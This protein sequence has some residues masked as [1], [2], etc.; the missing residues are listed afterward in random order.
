MEIDIILLEILFIIKMENFTT[1]EEKDNQIQKN[2]IRI[3]L[4]EIEKGI[5]SN[6]KV[7]Q[8][9]VLQIE[10]QIVAFYTGLISPKRLKKFCLEKLPKHMIPNSFIKLEEFPYDS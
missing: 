4:G 3:E 1:L 2:G 7:I 8:V 10:N 5:E 6:S 9:L